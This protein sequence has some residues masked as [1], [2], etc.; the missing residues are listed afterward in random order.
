MQ[1]KDI[2][3]AV[4][5]YA[6]VSTEDQ[7]ERQTIK[8]Q[9]D[10]LRKY[11]DLHALPVA[12][13]YIDDG[14]SGTVPLDE[15]S[16]GRRLL[17]DAETGRFGVVLVYRLDRLGR[18]LKAL[19]TAH[20]ALDGLG[21]AIRSG[22]EPF[23]TSSPIGRFVFQ[24]LGSIAELDRETIAERMMMGKRRVAAEGKYAGG[25]IPFGYDVDTE[26]RIVL[27]QR[28]L[29]GLDMTES[30]M[31]RDI[32]QRIAGGTTLLNEARRLNALGV[33]PLSR[34]GPN[35]RNGNMDRVTYT[36]TATWTPA[37]VWSLVTNPTYKGEAKLKAKQG[38]V[39]CPY[40]VLIEPALWEA[41]QASLRKNRLQATRNAK[42]VFLLRR[43]IA[44]GNCGGGF[45]GMSD[46]KRK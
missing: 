8:A 46:K 34:Y 30:T 27:S 36:Q 35:R 43:L 7:A 41:V 9:L 1:S 20:D 37:L 31:I 13:E 28:L 25:R 44:C 17:E 38:V 24:L 23:D 10:F 12:G 22:T 21:I 5:L 11:C 19:I 6:R 45:T 14:I 42:Q 39:A 16:E 33:A 2:T 29:S 26:G 32:F 15:R 18:S 40:P 3:P 4:A